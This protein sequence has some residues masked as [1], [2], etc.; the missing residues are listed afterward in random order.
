MDGLKFEDVLWKSEASSGAGKRCDVGVGPR[1]G[2]IYADVLPS[3]WSEPQARA[4][5]TAARVVVFGILARN[6]KSPSLRGR[7]LGVKPLA[8]T[9][10]RMA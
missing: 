8:M 1:G 10:S 2:G 7:G 3:K 9:Y 5:L 4:W 6:K